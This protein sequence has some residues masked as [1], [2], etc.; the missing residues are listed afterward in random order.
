[1]KSQYIHPSGS[2]RARKYFL[3]ATLILV[4]GIALSSR[5]GMA[6]GSGVVSLSGLTP[7]PV[8]DGSAKLV[9]HTD[10][11]QMLRLVIGL[12]PPNMAEEEQFLKDLQDK[13]S[14]QFHHF[15]TAEQ[16][17][18]RFA[19]SAASEQ[20]VVD[21][22][23][24]QG[25]TVTNR[26]SNRL[27]VDVEGSTAAIEKALN[28]TIN[29]YQLETKSFF[30]SD[31][32]PSIPA[33]LSNIVHS[34][35]GLNS[36]QVLHPANKTTQEPVFPVYAP[37]PVKDSGSVGNGDGDRTKLPKSSPGSKPT[38]TSPLI[39]G[40]AYDPTDIYSSQ[41]YDTNALYGQG[42][43]C[44]PLH[45]PNVT[46]PE[47][48][49]AIATAGTQN[50]SDIAGF[51]T[52]YP[53]LAYHY[54]Q[55]Y[56]DGTPGCCDGEGTMD[57]EWSTAM[58]NSFGSYVDTSMVY[59]YDGVNANF[60][61]FTDIYNH[62]LT[63]GYA[64]VFSTSW[65]CAE[66]DCYPTSVMDSNHA[67]FNSMVGQGW[68][69]VSISHDGGATTSC[70]HHDAVSYP[71]SDPD[72]V[73]SGGTQLYLS[74]GPFYNWEVGWT[75]G[76]AGCR[77]NDGGSGGGV[78]AYWAAPSYQN[79]GG[80]RQVPD[81]A[82]NADWY[83]TPQNIYFGGG[84]S[85]NGG[86]S[87]VAPE[88]AGFI[89]NANAYLLSLGNIC[90]GGSSP[91][92]PIG[93]A[94]YLLYL[95]AGAPHNPFYDI[96]SGCNNNDITAYYGLGYYCAAPGRDLVTGWGSFNM[97]QLGWAFNWYH[98]PGYTYPTVTFSGPATNHWYNTDQVVSWTVTAPPQNGYPSDGIAG[99]SQG[100]DFDPGDAYSEATPGAGNSFYSGPQYPNATAGCLD[101]TGASCAGSVGQGWHTVNVRAWG[102]EG[103]G[104]GDVTYGPIGYDTIPPVTTATLSGTLSGSTY[105]TAVQVTLTATDN[106]S[107]VASTVYQVDGGGVQT[108]AGPFVVSAAGAHTV[109]FHSVD[110][111]SN[112]ES[113]K[114]VSFTITEPT[115]TS[116]TSSKNPS[117]VGQ[118]VT[119]TSVVTSTSSV[120]GTAI[121][122]VTFKDGATT[123]ATKTLA[124]GK[125]TFGTSSLAFGNHSMTA[126]YSGSTYF[127]ASTSPV[128]NQVVKDVSTTALTSSLNPSTYGQAVTFT[129]TVSHT[130]SPVPTGT[131]TFKMGGTTL[132]TGTLDSSGVAT[133]TTS[134]LTAGTHTI[135]AVYGGDAN[136]L[137]STSAALHQVVN[138][139]TT[140]STVTSS[141]NPS[142]H[143]QKV[144]FTATVTST[145][146]TPTG[147][148]KFMDSATLLG[149]RSLSGGTAAF[150]TTTLTT[151]THNITVVYGG[152]SNF[153]GSTSPMLVQTVNP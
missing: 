115:A 75:G 91:C 56:I 140:S 55:F 112:V 40:G 62:M 16:W 117:G 145:G 129:A 30:S 120:T 9:G 152:S 49:I 92:A 6:Q 27:L 141:L 79:V 113:T 44:N 19:P 73:A 99:F 54:Q 90:G 14:P 47:T 109:S 66:I 42:H 77:A 138:K 153:A 98:V 150:S 25:L 39:T 8:L 23:Q 96:T 45:N 95:A 26:Y 104:S 151:G 86:T 108:Y 12:Q 3:G 53:Y 57:L 118:W 31:R 37:G 51:H 105:I 41:A 97:L 123:L 35:G 68:T 148:V 149:A 48:S 100:W 69:L 50:G 1:M 29:N 81:V 124:S 2:T 127:L 5:L 63:D 80:N 126:S 71:G 87:I 128:L 28:V 24:A 78:S 70:V 32:D 43:C 61:T 133:L 34:V 58:S 111:A 93:N 136:Y 65:G 135:T 131:V 21:W 143:G 130:A 114:S 33:T 17:N 76:P 107:G 36:L 142:H 125:A 94:N 4:A 10:S 101:F 146:G 46:P 83:Y 147:S 52:Q 132:G 103:E 84:L 89:A 72:V 20:A 106:A 60:S 134:T 7:G 82:L 74:S 13:Q 11:T 102:N 121:G 139:A 122:T 22:A 88:V 38:G 119:F 67:I 116:L 15:L 137:G 64:R 85:G 110:N 59:M 144:T 18:E